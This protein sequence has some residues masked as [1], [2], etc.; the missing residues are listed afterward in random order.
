MRCLVLYLSPYEHFL[1]I[2][3]ERLADAN[4]LDYYSIR[5]R[6]NMVFVIGVVIFSVPKAA[7]K[8]PG[9]QARHSLP[10]A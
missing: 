4:H 2:Y 9:S 3:L 5:I 7:A 10:V 6:F 8:H 1:E